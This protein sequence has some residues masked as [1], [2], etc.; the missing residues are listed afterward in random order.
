MSTPQNPQTVPVSNEMLMQKLMQMD[1]IGKGVN[2]LQ[3]GQLRMTTEIEHVKQQVEKVTTDVE[4]LKNKSEKN[5]SD[6]QGILGRLRKLEEGGGGESARSYQWRESVNYAKRV[7]VFEEFENFPES[8]DERHRII[9][10][11]FRD[12]GMSERDIE[13]YRGMRIYQ[14]DNGKANKRVNIEF[15]SYVHASQVLRMKTWRGNPQERINTKVMVPTY[16]ECYEKFNELDSVGYEIRQANPEFRYDIRYIG[17]DI[18]LFCRPA[19]KRPF[20]PVDKIETPRAIIDRILEK[21]KKSREARA[22]RPRR[23]ANRGKGR[24]K[25]P[26]EVRDEDTDNRSSGYTGETLI[27]NFRTTVSRVTQQSQSGQNRSLIVNIPN[28][29]TEE[30]RGNIEHFHKSTNDVTN[31]DVINNDVS[32][33]YN[34]DGNV[35]P[36]CDSPNK[37]ESSV[38]EEVFHQGYANS[39]KNY[40]LSRKSLVEKCKKKFAQDEPFKA[41]GGDPSFDGTESNPKWTSMFIEMNPVYYHEVKSVLIQITAEGK[42][43]TTGNHRTTVVMRKPIKDKGGIDEAHQLELSWDTRGKSKVVLFIYHSTFNMRIQGKKAQSWWEEVLRP[44]YREIIASRAEEL[45]AVAK[46]AKENPGQ[47]ARAVTGGT[48]VPGVKRIQTKMTDGGAVYKIKKF[49]EAAGKT[50][51]STRANLTPPLRSPVAVKCDVCKEGNVKKLTQCSSCHDMKGHATCFKDKL[52]PTCR[53]KP[54]NQKRKKTGA[55][56]E[57]LKDALALFT[58]VGGKVRDAENRLLER[59]GGRRSPPTRK[60]IYV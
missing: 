36:P 14:T 44:V 50:R 60:F 7:V 17:T 43:I 32:N 5:D 30:N 33:F 4:L 41:R 28:I 42:T 3:E 18:V 2:K 59:E 6:I 53:K 38:S 54:E 57:S 25:R 20:Y 58:R 13:K 39:M 26:H 16:R 31:F 49:G 45:R 55:D 8:E 23:E 27:D 35:S 34:F 1:E 52:C 40:N 19:P 51:Q 15:E 9:H 12:M 37:L 24:Q 47:A 48:D 56:S 21:D 29:H 46:L 22:T 10:G 11:V